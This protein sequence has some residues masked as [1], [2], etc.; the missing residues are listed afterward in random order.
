MLVFLKFREE[1]NVLWAYRID[2]IQKFPTVIDIQNPFTQKP[3]KVIFSKLTH[4][5]TSAIFVEG[6]KAGAIRGG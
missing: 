5:Q 6:N 2:T 3:T 4:N 1:M